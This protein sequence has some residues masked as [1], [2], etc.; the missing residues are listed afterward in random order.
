MNA[1]LSNPTYRVQLTGF[2]HFPCSSLGTIFS[3]VLVEKSHCFLK[4]LLIFRLVTGSIIIADNGYK[5][6][7]SDGIGRINREKYLNPSWDNL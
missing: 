4:I 6:L 3:A 7:Y 1:A 5:F 2:V